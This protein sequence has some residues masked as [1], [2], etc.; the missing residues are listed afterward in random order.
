MLGTPDR[1]GPVTFGE[2]FYRRCISVL[3]LCGCVLWSMHCK[4]FLHLPKVIPRKE[5]SA[6][7]SNAFG[8]WALF[9]GTVGGAGSCAKVRTVGTWGESV[10]IRFSPFRS[11]SEDLKLYL[12]VLD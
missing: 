5:H 11:G 1:R 8:A 12:Y 7:L 9:L 6:L 3:Y 10:Q 2:G 4:T